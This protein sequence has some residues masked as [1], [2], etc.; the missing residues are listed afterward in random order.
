MF[1][2]PSWIFSIGPGCDMDEFFYCDFMGNDHVEVTIPSD[3]YTATPSSIEVSVTFDY[4]DWYFDMDTGDIG[5]NM[6]LSINGQEK[7][8]AYTSEYYCEGGPG[9]WL[10]V[11]Y[12][13][14]V[15]QASWSDSNKLYIWNS[16]FVLAPNADGN[17]IELTFN[18]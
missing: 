4:L 18:Y 7:E 10:T 12:E 5:P 16:C 2:D 8:L 15:D 1:S 11:T 6:Y 9:D 17:Y 14:E 13:L 3:A